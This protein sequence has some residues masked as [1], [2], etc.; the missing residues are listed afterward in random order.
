MLIVVL[1]DSNWFLIHLSCFE[2]IIIYFVFH[3]CRFHFIT[4]SSKPVADFGKAGYIF[5][6]IEFFWQQ[7]A[8][9]LPLSSSGVFF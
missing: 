8:G 5:R 1:I 9:G 2:Y 6:S 4:S 3:D 7:Y